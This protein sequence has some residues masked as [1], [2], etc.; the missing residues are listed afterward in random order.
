MLFFN[1]YTFFSKCMILRL[2]RFLSP[3]AYP[4]THTFS[5]KGTLT[6][7]NQLSEL[8]GWLSQFWKLEMLMVF[9][10]MYGL[11]IIR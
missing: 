10:Y 7:K 8:K 11:F 9:A 1:F 4:V 5:E 6:N 2:R 3:S